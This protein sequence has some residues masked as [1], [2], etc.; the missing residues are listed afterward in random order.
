MIGLKLHCTCIIKVIMLIYRLSTQ[1]CRDLIPFS[2][3]SIFFYFIKYVYLHMFVFIRVIFLI[4]KIMIKYYTT[5]YGFTQ[6]SCGFYQPQ[7]K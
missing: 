1:K 6:L 4:P 7:F 5:R 3:L 2:S